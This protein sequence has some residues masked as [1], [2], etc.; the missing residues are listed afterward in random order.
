MWSGRSRC[1]TCSGSASSSKPQK[2]RRGAGAE[3]APRLGVVVQRRRQID[4]LV[5][6]QVLAPVSA[7][8]SHRQ[9]VTGGRAA[10]RQSFRKATST[11]GVNSDNRAPDRARRGSEWGRRQSR[12]ATTSRQPRLT[13]AGGSAATYLDGAVWWSECR[14]RG[15]GCWSGPSDESTK[16]GRG[17]CRAGEWGR[18]GATSAL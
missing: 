7:I 14:S 11:D 9:V 10:D 13:L 18:S 16:R 5:S 2:R 1:P 15:A 6:A 3:H 12:P 4:V 8:G 17:T